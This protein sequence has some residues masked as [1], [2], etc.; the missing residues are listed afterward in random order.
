MRRVYSSKGGV[1]SQRGMRT[2]IGEA[3]R[4]GEK[5]TKIRC[6]NTKV[7][8]NC[9]W[10]ETFKMMIEERFEIFKQAI[11]MESLSVS[12]IQRILILA[13]K[14]FEVPALSLLNPIGPPTRFRPDNYLASQSIRLPPPSVP[15]DP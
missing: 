3:D 14:V 13:R 2:I 8:L 5:V 9:S 1:G 11:L 12:R 7:P 10:A 6:K 4:K 15:T